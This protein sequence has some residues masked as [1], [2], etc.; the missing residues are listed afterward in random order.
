MNRNIKL[1][2]SAMAISFMGSLPLGTLNVSVAN[3]A[4]HHDIA[5]AIRFSLAAIVVEVL[6]VRIALVA[7]RWLERLRRFYPLFGLLTITTLV[8]LAFNALLGANNRHEF[9]PLPF[10]TLAP[11]MAG[12]LFSVINPLHLPFWM[13]WTA[14]L[15]SRNVLNNESS[16]YNTFVIAIGVGTAGAFTI[17]AIAGRFLIGLLGRQQFLLNYLIGVSLLITASLLLY[18]MFFKPQISLVKRLPERQWR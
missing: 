11:E 1:V 18:K 12:L 2:F 10:T 7:V 16:S 13:G 4:F 14:V 9:G 3:Y 17:Y 6:L 15:K 5:G 8:V